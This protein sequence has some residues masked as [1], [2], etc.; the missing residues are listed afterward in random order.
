[1]AIATTEATITVETPVNTQ[2]RDEIPRWRVFQ[3][4]SIE[5]A[6]SLIKE[7]GS[8]VEFLVIKDKQFLSETVRPIEN[9]DE[10]MDYLYRLEGRGI[11]SSDIQKFRSEYK[12]MCEQIKTVE[13]IAVEI[14]S[15]ARVRTSN[16]NL[17]RKVQ[18]FGRKEEATE[19]EKVEE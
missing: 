4:E 5:R 8:N 1:M 6:T 10:S 3:N 18:R 11:T 7:H 2:R 14:L 13:N 19:I 17:N 15:R 12:T 9:I 16:L